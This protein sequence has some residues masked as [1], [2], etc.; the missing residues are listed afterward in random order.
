VR[1]VQVMRLVDG[2]IVERWGSS[3]VLGILQQLELC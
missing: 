2:V 3:D 1:T